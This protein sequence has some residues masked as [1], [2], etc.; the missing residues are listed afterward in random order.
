MMEKQSREENPYKQTD[1]DHLPEQA[2]EL[3]QGELEGNQE[4]CFV[5]QGQGLLTDVT[6]NN[7]LDTKTHLGSPD[8]PVIQ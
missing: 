8:G 3:T 4:L 1:T 7:H 6:F 5:Q 2:E